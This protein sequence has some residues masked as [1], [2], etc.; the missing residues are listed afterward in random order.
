MIY[1]VR[2][3]FYLPSLVFYLNLTQMKAFA[4][5][6]RSY[7]QELSFTTDFTMP[8]FW[9][10]T[11]INQPCYPKTDDCH[12]ATYSY[13]LFLF[14]FWFLSF[15]LCFRIVVFILRKPHHRAQ[16]E[17]SFQ[18]SF[19]PK[20]KDWR[21]KSSIISPWSSICNLAW[22]FGWPSSIHF[23]EVFY[24][25]DYWHQDSK[26]LSLIYH[27]AANCLFIYWIYSGNHLN[28]ILE[29]I[30]KLSESCVRSF[31]FQFQIAE[32]F[33]YSLLA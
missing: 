8:F 4:P 18:F 7:F 32:K 20:T 22:V 1:Y 33:T 3:C 6:H 2:M 10:Q 9:L 15:N 24:L 31:P 26:R 19:C 30:K 27:S 17:H 12:I 29:P 21:W 16:L 23:L 11:C 25:R 5:R 14:E 28:S 13:D